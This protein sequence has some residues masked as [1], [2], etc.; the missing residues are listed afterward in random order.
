MI[1]RRLAAVCLGALAA[2]TGVQVQQHVEPELA[3]L[4]AAGYRIAVL[5]FTNRAPMEGFLTAQLAP[6]GELIALEG[7]GDLPMQ[8]RVPE[9]MRA[10]V[11]AWLQQSE[12]DVMDPWHVATRL[13]H[14]GIPRE[15]AADPAHAAELARALGV[16]GLVYGEVRRWNRDYFVVQSTVEVALHLELVDGPSGKRLFATDRSETIGSGLSGGPTGYVSAATEPLAGLR[17]SHLQYLTRSVTRHAVTDL[18]GGALGNQPG[19]TSPRLAVVAL[20][21]QH[22]GPFRRGERVA[23]IAVGTPDCDV[24]FD[25]GRLRT[26]VP[27]QQD[28]LDRDPRGDRATYLGHYVV[29]AADAAD[30]LPLFCTIQRGNARRT[31]ATRYRW[32]GTVAL[33]GSSADSR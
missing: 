8:Q 19:P 12:F 15:R 5:P 33:D 11:T 3:G 10:D 26:D 24:R 7:G 17:G 9:R 16:S 2:C 29:A 6:V 4:R 18:N 21:R 23:V 27:M 28:R 13:T 1:A 20:A 30:E 32:D 22:D 31:V 14:A 25:V